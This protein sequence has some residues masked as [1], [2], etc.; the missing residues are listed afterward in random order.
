MKVFSSLVAGIPIAVLGFGVG[1]VLGPE[2][3]QAQRPLG[4]DVSSYQ[5]NKVNWTNVKS[6]GVTFA[7]AKAG[8][9]T[10]TDGWVGQDPDFTVNA[11][12]AKAAGV[13]IGYYYYCHPETEV[14]VAGADTE[15]AFFWSVVKPYMK[16]DGLTLMP[17]LDFEQD[18]SSA[19][20]KYTA[21]TLS[22]WGNEWCQDIVNDGLSNGLTINPVF[23]TYISYADGGPGFN[24]TVTQWPLDMANYPYSNPQTG[25]PSSTYPWSSW[26]FWQYNT[27]NTVPGVPGGPCDQDVFNGTMTTL[28]NFI[29][30]SSGPLI[31][32]QPSNVTVIQGGPA[33]LTVTGTNGPLA[34][35]WFFN[36]TNS[37]TGATN[38]A[39]SFTNAQTN[40]NGNYSA[41]AS[42]ISG[43]VTSSN[44][45]LTVIPM[46][47]N[48]SAAARLYSAIITW[49]TATNATGQVLYST[50]SSYSLSTL[51][52]TNLTT[53]H[54]S[55]L[56]GLQSNA[57]YNFEVVSSNGVYAGTNG[58]SFST[59]AAIIMTSAQAKYFGVWTVASAS[60]QKYGQ[61]YEYADTVNGSDTAEAVFYPNIPVAG[62]YDVYLWYSA[63]TNRSQAAPVI[64]AYTGGDAEL[65]VNEQ[66]NGGSWQLLVSGAYFAAGTNE[67][68]RLGNGS[69][70]TGLVVIADAVRFQYS[71]DQ[72][73]PTNNTPPAWWLSY[74]FGTNTVNAALDTDGDGYSTLAEYIMGTDP[75]SPASHLTVNAQATATGGMQVVFA[76]YYPN[77]GRQYQLQGSGGLTGGW[78]NVPA[79]TIATNGTGG[80]IITLANLAA[81]QSFMRVSVAMTQQ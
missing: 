80:G 54:S 15:A 30:T 24:S 75:T 73:L 13:I 70:E 27:D 72:D 26:T 60:P 61:Y 9:G 37:I 32:T 64:A 47:S 79:T 55:L 76:P 7:W 41:V 39:L 68:V 31:T 17:M 28:S 5:G 35:Q 52:N 51:V 2:R 38:S 25:G 16:A 57:T 33:S 67:Y 40:L 63:E 53:Q 48:V 59:D 12:N 43:S 4:I 62:N 81:T 69:G 50:D 19:S 10:G 74:Y 23:Y 56:A 8:E 44:A 18:V 14:G 3:A 1:I 77:S 58:G 65:S 6:S 34:Y 66:A 71:A 20:P 42:S 11:V 21:A 49:S 22:A 46:I 36:G 78:T 29:I 45:L